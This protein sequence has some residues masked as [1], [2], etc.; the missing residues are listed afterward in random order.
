MKTRLVALFSVLSLLIP[1]LKA[2]D[3]S[4]LKVMTFN[5]RLDTESDSAN[6][7]KFRKDKLCGDILKQQPHLLGVQEALDNQMIDM[8]ESLKGY[9]SLGVARDDGKKSG[10]Y[11]AIFYME[12][13]LKP[14]RSGTFWLSE[15]PDIPGSR[16]W[17]A[18]CNRVVTWAEFIHKQSGKHFMAMNTH[19]DHEGE[20][21]RVESAKLIIRKINEL[22]NG[23]PV[24][25]TGD[26]N[27]TSDHEA[28]KILT[29]VENE[30]HLMDS[31]VKAGDKST[32]PAYSFVGFDPNF[33]PTQLI[34]YILVTEEVKVLS[35]AIHDFTKKGK[36]LSD[37]LPVTVVVR[38]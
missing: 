7:W 27:I 10:E 26:L 28:Y 2:Q 37:H 8:R 31:R 16:G 32:G 5:I 12:K 15:T 36:Y 13:E 11:S 1:A 6:Q 38:F 4:A 3:S 22:S 14:V 19:F 20:T 25:V 21:A 35:H 24:I 9:K 18:A 33:K 17:D 30:R 34:D 23:L 29:D